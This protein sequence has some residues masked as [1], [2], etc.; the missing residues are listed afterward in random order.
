MSTTQAAPAVNTVP[1]PAPSAN[2]EAINAGSP[3]MK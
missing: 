1:S 2:R 3:G